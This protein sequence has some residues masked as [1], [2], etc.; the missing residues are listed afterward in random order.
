MKRRQFMLSR[1]E[2]YED[3]KQ[4]PTKIQTWIYMLLADFNG[5]AEI[6][7][8]KEKTFKSNMAAALNLVDLLP[9]DGE[10]EY[11]GDLHIA[12][13]DHLQALLNIQG[14]NKPTPHLPENLQYLKDLLNLSDCELNILELCIHFADIELLD[15]VSSG[16]GQLSD[17]LL[18]RVLSV[19]LQIPLDEIK[20]SLSPSSIL[21]KSGLV[22]VDHD[23]G[24]S[25][26]HKIRLI[27]DHFFEAMLSEQ[28]DGLNF[29]A[30]VIKACIPPELNIDDYS[31]IEKHTKI[32]KPYLESS[33]V[34]NRQGVNILI[35][36]PPGTGKTEYVRTI[37]DLLKTE[38]YE[39]TFED[40]DG[41]PIDAVRRLR[42]YKASQYLL[43]SRQAILLFDEIED[44]FG[45]GNE[46]YG[47]RSTAQK[48]KAWLNHALEQNTAPTVWVSNSIHSIDSA[49]IRRFDYIFELPNPTKRYRKELLQSNCGDFISEA[50]ISSISK[51]EGLSPAIISRST[52]VIKQIKH[53]LSEEE[54]EDA[55]TQVIGN[56]LKSQGYPNATNRTGSKLPVTYKP[57][58]INAD[59]DLDAISIGLSQSQSARLCIYGPPGTGKTAY[60][61]WLAEQLDKELIVKKCSDLLSM[62]VG[63]TE[64]NLSAAFEEAKEENAILLIDEVD[65]FLQDRNKANHSWEVTAVNEMLTQMENFEGI[66][67]ASTNLM[68]GLDQ[69]ALRRFD[70]KMK[71]DYMKPGQANQLFQHYCTV[72]NIDFD[73]PSDVDIQG[74]ENSTPGD[75]AAIARQGR[76]NPITSAKDFSNRILQEC[77]LKN[78]IKRPIGFLN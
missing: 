73:N 76:F 52:S 26:K 23:K 67:I 19:L 30:E 53:Q 7:D 25:L 38:I 29:F 46:F 60:G 69:A 59:Q 9:H 17:R 78:P 16:I 39:I 12:V 63:G 1:H 45:N 4:Y 58:Y 55:L 48:Y 24:P 56:T 34:L 40:G 49:F 2:P 57:C 10:S 35:Y 66:F 64:Q 28:I 75:F 21:I 77:N 43:K 65:S 5:L 42:A 22:D 37:A 68:E 41:D 13:H 50:A 6:Y 72:L 8:I 71:F 33:L 18:Y 74:L 20:Q 14:P 70:L 32:L 62:F 47:V 15:E 44:V 51:L 36:G 3:V 31:H 61:H 11:T 54:R 27:S